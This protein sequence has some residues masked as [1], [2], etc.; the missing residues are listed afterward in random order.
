MPTQHIQ[1]L[2]STSASVFKDLSLTFN[3]DINGKI[4]YHSQIP[5]HPV[6]TGAGKQT[7]GQTPP[8]REN[9]E[10]QLKPSAGSN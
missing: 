7:N 2:N 1:Q 9:L 6:F 4:G 5:Q 3:L 8:P 10:K